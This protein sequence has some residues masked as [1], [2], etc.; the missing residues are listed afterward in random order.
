MERVVEFIAICPTCG[1][2][3]PQ[4]YPAA[5]LQ[6]W[7]AQNRLRLDCDS[8]CPRWTPTPEQLLRIQAV[9]NQALP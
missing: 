4:R 3:I 7:I 1:K 2:L 8:G 9:L 6:V 5:A